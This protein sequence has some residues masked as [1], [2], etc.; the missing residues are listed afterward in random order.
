MI[1]RKSLF[2]SSYQIQPKSTPASSNSITEVTLISC[3]RKGAF[4]KYLSCK[5][6]FE[7]IGNLSNPERKMDVQTPIRPCQIDYLNLMLNHAQ[8]IQLFFFFSF[9]FTILTK[10]ASYRTVGF[11]SLEIGKKVLHSF[12]NVFH[13]YLM[14]GLEKNN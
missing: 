10:L 14:N 12:D 2:V 3:A 5:L 1:F 7:S 9:C 11:W 4:I 6:S 8:V 13:V